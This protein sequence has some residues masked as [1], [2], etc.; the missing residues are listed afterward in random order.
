MSERQYQ[1]FGQRL[2]RIGQHHRQIALGHATVM[3]SDGLL[4]VQPMKAK[5]NS[6]AR[7][8][9]ICLVVM[10]AFKIAMHVSMGGV[11]YQERVT[12]LSTGT[13][14]QKVGGFAMTADPVTVL[15][16]NLASSYK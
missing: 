11:A 2:S 8:L 4:V 5:S 13:I 15:F 3:N 12:A 1:Q 14:V 10:W 6:T 9:F 7:S 16:A